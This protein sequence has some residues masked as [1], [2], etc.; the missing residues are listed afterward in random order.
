MIRVHFTGADFARIS[1]S[2]HPAPLVELKLSL[3]M[4][5]RRDNDVFFGRW[6]RRLRKSLPA[7]TR[8]LWDLVSGDRGPAFI[9]PVSVTLPEGLDAVHATPARRIKDDIERV[10][11]HRTSPPPPWLRDLLGGDA[12]A[13]D[14]LRRALEDAYQATL[15]RT[16]PAVRD[17]HRAEFTRYALTAAGSGVSSALTA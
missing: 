11:A 14:T 17:L 4:L 2:Q 3:M 7:T 13:W 12:G 6:R 8:P 9:D 10:Y 16:W 15:A 1:I 5:S